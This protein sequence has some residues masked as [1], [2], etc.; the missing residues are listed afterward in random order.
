MRRRTI[1]IGLAVIVVVLLV[2]L[3]LY[4]RRR[5][6]PEAARL[7]PGGDAMLY[8]NL[9]PIRAFSDL[10]THPVTLE[11]DYEQFVRETGFQF[12]RDL[13]EAALTVH[14]SEVTQLPEGGTELQRR[15]SEIFIGKFDAQ[16][17]KNYLQK[18]SSSVEPYRSTEIFVIPH[19]GRTVR[20]AILSVDTVAV[21]NVSEPG[22]IHG[23]IDRQHKIA[24][25][26]GGPALLRRFYPHIPLGS[27]AWAIGRLPSS[28]GKGFAVPFPGGELD[29]PGDTTVVA[30][31][32][33]VGAIQFKA[34]AFTPSDEAANRLADTLNNF[35]QLTRAIE[36]STRPSGPDPDVK[37]LFDS[38][39]VKQ[40]KDRVALTAK[41]PQ[42]LIKKLLTEAPPPPAPAPETKAPK[43]QPNQPKRKKSP[44]H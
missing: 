18:I 27:V 35:L 26:F 44:T 19:Q 43:A 11:P 38:L 34:E 16:R 5:A 15:F 30:S 21:S 7:L 1:W 33:Y 28:S 13:D 32:R 31:L 36:A 17:V 25:P 41:V 37:M 3:A 8:V 10:G 42:G 24:S 9:Q 40:E 29:L 39:E 4:L 12:E 22:V 2:V 14:P 20:V 23:I 6:A